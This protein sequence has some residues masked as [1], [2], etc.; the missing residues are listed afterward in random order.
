[1]SFKESLST[2]Y[3]SVKLLPDRLENSEEALQQFSANAYRLPRALVVPDHWRLNLLNRRA[4]DVT[5]VLVA[6]TQPREFT[7]R[8]FPSQCVA[9]LMS[10]V[11]EQPPTSLDEL[12]FFL[13]E[14]TEYAIGAL[15]TEHQM[16]PL[17]TATG[18]T[19]EGARDAA[20]SQI[21]QQG[22]RAVI[23]M[24]PEVL[25]EL[26]EMIARAGVRE[27]FCADIEQRRPIVMQ[28]AQKARLRLTSAELLYL[29]NL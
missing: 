25:N 27:Y 1:M 20:A 22:Y 21:E 9:H 2:D 19:A 11:E 4:P 15:M 3:R 7:A 8:A 29:L 14:S 17:L 28:L 18:S 10:Y 23:G 24:R 13:G 6:Q 12:V 5:I 26:V 16:A